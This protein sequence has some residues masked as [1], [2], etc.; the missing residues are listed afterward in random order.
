MK[1]GTI[2]VRNQ[3]YWWCEYDWGL[4][5]MPKYQQAQDLFGRAD[6]QILQ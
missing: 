1:W 5:K 3:W 4:V 2:V 6:I